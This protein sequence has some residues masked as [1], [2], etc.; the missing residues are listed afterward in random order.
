VTTAVPPYV[1]R[2]APASGGL[3]G[4][5]LP[6]AMLVISTPAEARV[7][8]GELAEL[9][10]LSPAESRIAFALMVS[11]RLTEL[12]N[13]FGVQIRT[14]RTQLSSL[15]AKCRVER[16]SDLVR[17]ISTIPRPSSSTRNSVPSSAGICCGARAWR[18]QRC[19]GRSI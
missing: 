6:M 15:L 16:Q 1:V 7:S 12:V 9:Y 11:K 2:V 8:R 18:R 17:L 3:T 19:R 10:G 5:D 14:L 13:E 4:D